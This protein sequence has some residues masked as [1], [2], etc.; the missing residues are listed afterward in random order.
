[1]ELGKN[2]ML[3]VDDCELSSART[4]MPSRRRNMLLSNPVTLWVG[5]RVSKGPG[6]RRGIVLSLRYQSPM[7]SLEGACSSSFTILLLVENFVDSGVEE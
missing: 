7:T 3:G 6:N 1:M 4:V 5:F 2:L